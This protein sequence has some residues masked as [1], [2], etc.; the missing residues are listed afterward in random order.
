MQ[1][2]GLARFRLMRNAHGSLGVSSVKSMGALADEISTV[3]FPG[4]LLNQ[5]CTSRWHGF[6]GFESQS[7]L[8]RRLKRFNCGL[9][10][11]GQRV[12]VGIEGG[13]APL[14]RYRKLSWVFLEMEHPCLLR[15]PV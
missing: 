9:V 4:E 12:G 14:N 13:D 3:L 15:S 11:S 1:L 8:E 7:S 10:H 6:C 2:N 5:L